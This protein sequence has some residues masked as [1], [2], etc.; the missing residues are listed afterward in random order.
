MCRNLCYILTSTIF[1][2][3][4]YPVSVLPWVVQYVINDAAQPR[5][6]HKKLFHLCIPHL[7]WE[8]LAF[9]NVTLEMTSDN[10]DKKMGS[11]QQEGHSSRGI[12]RL[13]VSAIY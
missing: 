1:D 4:T 9:Q 3:N 2:N 10:S 11:K 8:M 5:G 7:S 6:L 12:N 13:A